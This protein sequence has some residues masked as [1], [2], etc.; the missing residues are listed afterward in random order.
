MMVHTM[1]STST[2]TALPSVIW[3]L[4]AAIG[5]FLPTQLGRHF[6]PTFSLIGGVRVDYLAPTFY[7]IDFF[8][9]A[10]ILLHQQVI[11]RV[12]RSRFF[13]GLV[14]VLILNAAFSQLP[15]LSLYWVLRTI[16]MVWVAAIVAQTSG[17]VRSA[18][19]LGSLAGG[20]FQLGIV[21]L[22]LV[23]R[24]SVGGTLWLVGERPLSTTLPDIAKV[25][26]AGVEYLRP[27]G[28]FS[29]PNAM[30]GYYA[31]LAVCAW[32]LIRKS[33]LRVGLLSLSAALVVLSLSRGA[34][35]SWVVGLGM[36]AY[37]R[38]MLKH[39][40]K[41]GVL[42]LVCL[43]MGLLVFSRF[44]LSDPLSLQKRM[45]LLEQAALLF[46]SNPLTG[47][48][49]GAYVSAQA[50]HD[51]GYAYFF[52]QPVH[53]VFML[54]IVEM[55]IIGAVWAVWCGWQL[56]LRLTRIAPLLAVIVVSGLADHYWLTL[57][58]NW[59]LMWIVGG[60]AL[61]KPKQSQ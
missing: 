16:E 21:L 13:Q 24:H 22:Q 54:Y 51:F 47:V 43:V 50:G 41:M 4:L 34:L 61:S 7:F 60:I 44:I 38:F 11:G 27:Y 40:A 9:I 57:I 36:W 37:Q 23:L 5:F 12:L 48:G 26:I 56:R 17:V 46:L 42:A 19:W 15:F 14:L 59:H 3:W 8:L 2:N 10:L 18:F 45:A 35:A 20:M 31:L 39:R 6:F 52:V 55:G 32:L 33:S 49:R 1:K 28:T 58:Q 53:S 25:T 29:H 30:G